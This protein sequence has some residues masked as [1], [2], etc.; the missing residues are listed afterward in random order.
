MKILL[1]EDEKALSSAEVAVLQHFGYEVQPAYDGEEAWAYAQKE[2]YD[3]IVLDIMMP[4]MDG[5]EVLKNIRA[6]GDVTPVIM[7]T[8]KTE[9]DDRITGLDAGAD[10]YLTKP[11]AM[12]EFLARIRSMTRRASAFTP[13]ELKLGNVALN[14]EEQE[15]SS[16]NAVRLGSKETK[17]MK[18]LM[19]N[20][21]KELDTDEIL[22]HVW[23][24]EPSVSKEIVWM[25]ISFLREKVDAIHGD[26]QIIG[27]KDGPYRLVHQK[28]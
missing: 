3:C 12:G 11:F 1:A 15:L 23:D 18:L 6:S 26:I 28:G 21:G 13:K 16:S 24:D 22:A 25:Y 2:N 8:A 10:D 4:K 14:V 9:V 27:E 7:L 19:M 20:E 5:I 17:L